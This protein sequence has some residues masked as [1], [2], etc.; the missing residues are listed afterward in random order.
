MAPAQIQA[1]PYKY[2]IQYRPTK[3]WLLFYFS[4]YKCSVKYY[5]GF[6]R[7]FFT[8]SLKVRKPGRIP[9]KK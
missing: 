4:N 5:S 3:V 8:I 6:Q 9:D 1:A 7:R 2:V